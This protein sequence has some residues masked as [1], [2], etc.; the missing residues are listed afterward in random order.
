MAGFKILHNSYSEKYRKPFGAVTEGE[1]I[2]LRILVETDEKEKLSEVKL[3]SWKDGELPCE[4]YM[5][6][7]K[8]EAGALVF[9]SEIIAP[10]KPG[11]VWYCFRMNLDGN[12]C[13]YGNNEGMFG[14]IGHPYVFDPKAY[15]ITVYK[16]GFKTPDWIKDGTMYQIFVD[17]FNK[18]KSGILDV[19]KNS[20]LYANWDDLPHYV[21]DEKGHIARWDF[22][23]GNLSGVMEKL[24][25]IADLGVNII[26]FN[27]LFEARSNHKYDTA[28]YMKIDSMFGTEEVFKKLCQ[29]A[30]KKGIKVVLD[31]VFSHTGADSRYFNKFGS[32]DSLGAYQ[33]QNSPYYSWYRFK[34]S[35]DD[36]DS[37]W[38][39]LDLPNV[40]EEDPS[41]QEYIYGDGDSVINHWLDAGASGWRLDV[42]DELPDDFI[43]DLR[44]TIKAKNKEH[45][46]IGEVWE[47]ATNK[48]SYEKRRNYLL[49]EGLDGVMNYP[50]RNNLISFLNGRMESGCFFRRVMNIKENYPKESFYSLMNMSS[51]HDSV[52]LLTTLGEAPNSEKMSVADQEAYKLT[53]GQ[54]DRAVK[55]LKQYF[56]FIATIP[57]FPSIYYGDEAG[58]EGFKD[59]LNR[60]TFPWGKEDLEIQT[61]LKTVM[62]LRGRHQALR[63]GSFVPFFTEN[64][65]FGYIRE[66]KGGIDEFGRKAA[67]ERFIVLFN[68][69][70]VD[71]KKFSFH[72]VPSRLDI[73]HELE[74]FYDVQGQKLVDFK[75]KGEVQV[76]PNGVVILQ[77]ANP[78]LI[79]KVNGK[80]AVIKKKVKPEMVK[81]EDRKMTAILET[82]S[83]K[84]R[85]TER[86]PD[87]IKTSNKTR[88]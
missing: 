56:A 48:I 80:P 82:A 11:L 16:S 62:S 64:D 25:Y 66:I 63:T 10:D 75:A 2:I 86:K 85:K 1:H 81:A 59:P 19:K 46:I 7:V 42:A 37:W 39:V 6:L 18:G 76:P 87:K 73:S 34:G 68:R 26:Y 44:K 77:E 23:G 58:V 53:D 51:T 41:Y 22:F 40:N 49:G 13:F 38:G 32:Y 24:N 84:K 50:Y 69:D 9:E 57:G 70:M 83:E 4:Q 21:K 8:E 43:K 30:E 61:W 79:E 28:D 33:S 88:G 3:L 12:N 35:R 74:I 45:L 71:E 47:D 5:N 20:F 52:R 15:Q 31:G 27:P 54:R 36:Y 17:R 14:G 29:A 72:G 78:K 55:R 67:D 65:I 60:R